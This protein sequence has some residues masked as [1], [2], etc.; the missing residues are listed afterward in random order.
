MHVSECIYSC[1]IPVYIPALLVESTKIHV[2]NTSQCSKYSCK[3][4]STLWHPSDSGFLIAYYHRGLDH[5]SIVYLA[6]A[7]LVQ[8]QLHVYTGVLYNICMFVYVA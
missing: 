6:P 1:S 8:P 5:S 4:P 3:L 2:L 7:S